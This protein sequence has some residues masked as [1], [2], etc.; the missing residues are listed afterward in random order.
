MR[1]YAQVR[2]DGVI[3]QETGG[4]GPGAGR[5]RRHGA[6][7][8]DRRYLKTVIEFY[9]GGPVGIE[10]IAATLQEE[11]DTLVD[12]VEPYLLKIGL[13]MRTSSGRKASEAAYRHLGFSV[14]QS[15]SPDAR[16]RR[17]RRPAGALPWPWPPGWTRDLPGKHWFGTAHGAH[18]SDH[19]FR[20]SEDEY[21]GLLKGV[22]LGID[23][24]A[25]VVHVTH[26]IKPQ[27]VAQA[28]FVLGGL[29]P[30]FPG[31]DHPHGGRSPGVC[32]ERGILCRNSTG[33]SSWHRTRYPTLL[34]EIGQGAVLRRREPGPPRAE[35]SAVF[36]G[37][38][39][40]APAAAHLSKGVGIRALGPELAC[41]GAVRSERLRPVVRADAGIDGAI[42]HVDRFGNL[43]RTSP[44]ASSKGLGERRGAHHR[45]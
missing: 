39:I 45:R 21:V 8:L 33:K 18:Y 40:I 36:H 22:I 31:G 1:D 27:D 11:A 23:P 15:F 13:I 28:A 41:E 38:D 12:V 42:V 14:Q 44:P 4:R 32:T 16:R 20:E 26:A 3:N 9:Q 6:D 24:A 17:P 25:V 2:A 30:L 7:H 10:A 43:I 19:G 34:L 35:V 37:R 29:V 5:G